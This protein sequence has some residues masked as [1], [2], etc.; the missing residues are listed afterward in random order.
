M[1]VHCRMTFA[2]AVWFA[3]TV[4]GAVPIQ[5]WLGIVPVAVIETVYMPGLR[6][7]TSAVA[8]VVPGAE[9]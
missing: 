2:I 1:R 7:L 8:W 4:N 5:V 6:P 3:T 9:T